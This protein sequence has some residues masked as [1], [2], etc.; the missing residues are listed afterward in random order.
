[1]AAV[2]AMSP[3]SND[4]LYLAEGEPETEIM[5]RHGHKICE[6][7]LFEL[8]DDRDAVRYTEDMYRRYFDIVAKHGPAALLAGFD[9]RASADWSEKLGYLREGLRQM[10]KQVR[11]LPTRRRPAVR[12]S[13]TPHRDCRVR[14]PPRLCLF[15]Q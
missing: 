2:G 12:K 1:M 7:A 14:W 6:F 3:Q 13:D 15:T 8:M 11:R 4:V 10:Q 9:Y 5:F